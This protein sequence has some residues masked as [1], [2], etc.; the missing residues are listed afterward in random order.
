VRHGNLV[1]V[2]VPKVYYE[3]NFVQEKEDNND[4]EKQKFIGLVSKNDCHHWCKKVRNQVILQK[5]FL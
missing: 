1:T 2:G 3:P 5:Y 4:F